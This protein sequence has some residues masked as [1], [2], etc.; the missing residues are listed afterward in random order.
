MIKKRIAAKQQVRVYYYSLKALQA[1]ERKHPFK[2]NTFCFSK[3]RYAAFTKAQMAQWFKSHPF[4]SNYKFTNKSYTAAQWK[5][6]DKAHPFY[7]DP[8]KAR[9]KNTA[10]KPQKPR[11]GLCLLLR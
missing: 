9:K 7:N 4:K 10:V 11:K 3:L 2:N 6:W 8:L 5:A 1:W